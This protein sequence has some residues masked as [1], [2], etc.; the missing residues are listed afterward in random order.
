MKQRLYFTNFTWST[1]G[2]IAS[3]QC[4]SVEVF[5]S[6]FNFL[7][8]FAKCRCKSCEDPRRFYDDEGIDCE[9][10]QCQWLPPFTG[11]YFS[12]LKK[13]HSLKLRDH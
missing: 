8:T 5:I 2:Y 9:G 1:L 7:A 4:S 11:K 6:L 13:N 10:C 12:I 3:N